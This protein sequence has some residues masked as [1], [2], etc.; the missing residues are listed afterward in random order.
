MPS[1]TRQTRREP[2]QR[3]AVERRIA[4]AVARL[5]GEGHGYTSLGVQRIAE[6]A[7]I[8]RSTFYMHF[9]DKAA[10]LVRIAESAT[11]D[12]FAAAGD[13]VEHGFSDLLALRSTL[14]RLVAQQR[15]HA[16]LLAAV[17]ELAAYDEEVAAF[18]RGRVGE[19]AQRLRLRIEEGQ[20]AGTIACELD[21]E[22]T[23]AW[24]AW[25]TERLLAQHTAARSPSE[26][27]RLVAGLAQAI[28]STLARSDTVDS[29]A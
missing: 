11:E 23:A 5:L 3:Q 25:G 14:T 18:W 26:D 21:A 7:G 17:A 15:Q 8:A 12:L 4:Q 2:A 6:E 19:F 27:E 28:W 29:V 10:L 9:P 22:T 24:M 13:W 1:V 16:T 20:A